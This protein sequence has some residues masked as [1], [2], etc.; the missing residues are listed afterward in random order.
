MHI[1]VAEQTR[2]V[3]DCI[4]W[5]GK[6]PVE[7]LLSRFGLSSRWC[8]IHAT[9]MTEN[10]TEELARSGAIAGLCPTT[11][12]NLGDGI[13]NGAPFLAAGGA[14]ALGSDSHISM[15]PPEE[16]RQL[17]Y[18]QRLQQRARNVLA[19]GPNRSTGRR[20][21]DAALSGGAK[22]LAQ[23]QGAITPG[24]RA[25]IIVLDE[26]HPALIGRSGDNLLNSWIFSG[27]NPCVKHVFVGGEQLVK[28][29]RHRDEA[30]V[31][32]R[33]EKAMKRLMN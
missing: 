28:D 20:L 21:L 31:A 11:E 8:L 18:S 32:R 30:A 1:H 33:F 23:P 3:D 15:S 12:A 5:C 22:A 16:I 29:R 4:A 26:T 6:R 27:G 17:E 24:M 9:H 10:E 14:I 2:E 19:G 25:D 7:L 13:F